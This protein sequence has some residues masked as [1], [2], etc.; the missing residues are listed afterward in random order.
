[1][2]PDLPAIESAMRLKRI[3]VSDRD[4]LSDRV[5][6]FFR[7]ILNEQAKGKTKQKKK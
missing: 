2:A 5:L 3:P 1:M 4:E 6:L 7:I